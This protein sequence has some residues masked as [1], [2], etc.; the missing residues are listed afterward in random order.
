MIGKIQIATRMS[1][2]ILKDD[3]MPAVTKTSCQRLSGSNLYS[4]NS[5]YITGLMIKTTYYSTR[6]M[7][8]SLVCGTKTVDLL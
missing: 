2:D 7:K 6:S 8:N 1:V 5:Q 3:A 4:I